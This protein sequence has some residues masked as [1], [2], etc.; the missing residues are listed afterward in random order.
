MDTRESCPILVFLSGQDSSSTF[1]ANRPF[2][3]AWQQCHGRSSH[4]ARWNLRFAISHLRLRIEVTVIDKC[5]QATKG[6]R[7][8]PWHREAM[9]DVVACD[10]LREVGKQTLIRRFLNAETRWGNPPSLLRECIAQVER[11]QGT[12]TS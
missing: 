9:K 5:G 12:E 6:V 8:M 2:I 11:T 3:G 7:W 10:Q 1:S 4:H